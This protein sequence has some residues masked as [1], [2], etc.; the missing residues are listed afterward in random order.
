MVEAQKIESAAAPML[1]HSQPPFVDGIDWVLLSV[2]QLS[3][4][5]YENL[6]FFHD[7]VTITRHPIALE[8]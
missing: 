1:S 7:K 5:H 4:V 6:L 3:S 8:R 2:T